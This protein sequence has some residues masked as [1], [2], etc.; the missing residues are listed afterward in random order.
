MA[1][2]DIPGIIKKRKP[3]RDWIKFVLD[4]QDAIDGG[5]AGGSGD[6]VTL[7]TSQTITGA[8]DFTSAPTVNGKPVWNNDNVGAQINSL[9]IDATP[10]TTADYMVTYDASTDTAKRVLLGSVGGGSSDDDEL[11]HFWFD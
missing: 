7:G 8:K 1:L 6:Y 3:Q 10:D 2:K 4:L 5:T 9:P 11:L